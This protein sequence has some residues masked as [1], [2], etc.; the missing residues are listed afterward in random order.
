M[1]SF[2]CMAHPCT[3]IS[4]HSKPNLFIHACVCAGA[5]CSCINSSR[6]W[7][8]KCVAICHCNI[9]YAVQHMHLMIILKKTACKFTAMYG[10]LTAQYIINVGTWMMFF[11]MF[12]FSRL[13]IDKS[14]ADERWTWTWNRPQHQQ[15]CSLWEFRVIIC[16]CRINN[17]VT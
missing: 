11:E 7:K 5:A 17:L 4:E 16:H 15:K 9:H 14:C 12:L 6:Y 8:G 2:I 10:I 1:Y 3:R 13:K